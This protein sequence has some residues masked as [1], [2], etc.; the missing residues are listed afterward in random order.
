MQ[1]VHHLVMTTHERLINPCRFRD[2]QVAGSDE[3]RAPLPVGN[4]FKIDSRETTLS[5]SPGRSGN[6]GANELHVKDNCFRFS[7]VVDLCLL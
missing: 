4:R 6:R 1:Y 7:Y 5:R 3:V 2:V